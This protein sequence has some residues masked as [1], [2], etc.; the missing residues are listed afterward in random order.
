MTW[1]ERITPWA[2]VVGAVLASLALGWL[3][4]Q[5]P[6]VAVAVGAAV[7][8]LGVTALSSSLVP[9]L[10][11][12]LLYVTHRVGSG[13]VDLTV[14]DTALAIGVG[15]A[16]VFGLRT[17][18]ASLRTL[19]WLVGLYQAATLF[20]VIANPY[21]ANTVEWVHAWFLTG[22]AL[23]LGWTVGRSGHGSLGLRLMLAA[24]CVIAGWVLVVAG[25]ALAR[26]SLEPVYLPFGMHKNFLGTVLGMTALIAY[27]SPRWV[28]L[29]RRAA[30]PVFWWLAIALAA[31][32]SRQA[33]VGLAVALLVLV[34]RTRTDRRRSRLILLG[35]IPAVF[36]VLTLVREQIATGNEFNSYFTRLTWFRESLD[37]ASQSPLVGHGLRWWY[38]E[39]M[40]GNIQPPNAELEVLTSAGIIGLVAFVVLLVG[41]IRVLA[42]VD[43]AYG[44]LAMLV[45]L[46]RVVQTQFD[47]FWIAAQTSIPFVIV[48]I[49]L[50]ALAL[51]DA[52][53]AETEPTADE[54]A[55]VE[56]PPRSGAAVPA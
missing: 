19:L 6:V 46:S 49:C 26:G 8:A 36:V 20:T 1:R 42:R 4:P 22:G 53:R 34:L 35:I 43:P 30:L 31:T 50:G 28:G 38:R 11:L 18:S 39:D 16:L 17:H 7:L 37:I 21:A 12:P 3:A 10:C 15:T 25:L 2:L 40:A 47:A 45:L 44:T 55:P 33:V 48:G 9:L 24:A 56:H 27:V 54:D 51:R 5:Q 14:S 23:L 52:D 32:Q 41:G 13:G 29:S